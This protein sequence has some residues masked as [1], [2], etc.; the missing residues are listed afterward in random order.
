MEKDW[1]DIQPGTIGDFQLKKI[2]PKK[3]ITKCYDPGFVKQTCYELRVGNTVWYTYLRDSALRK[4]S[5][6]E[7]GGVYLPPKAYATIITMEELEL[8]A[9]CVARIMTKGQLFSIGISAVNT[10]ADPGFIGNLGITLINHSNKP[11]FIPI[12]EPIAKIEFVKLRKE[13]SEPYKGPH[14]NAGKLWPIP[15][16]YYNIPPSIDTTEYPE[17]LK[18]PVIKEI[19]NKISL[20]KNELTKKTYTLIALFVI[21]VSLT[22]S[23]ILYWI[24]NWPSMSSTAKSVFIIFLTI[25]GALASIINYWKTISGFFLKLFKKDSQ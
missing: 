19:E 20:I 13:I 24:S 12:G 9:D 3:L 18:E 1:D 16:A 4:K 10:Y 15:D 17:E 7:E 6:K 11:V 25:S 23:S 22:I 14:L 8:P 2:C 5:I 21:I